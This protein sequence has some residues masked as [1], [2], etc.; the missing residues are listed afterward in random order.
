MQLEQEIDFK[1]EGNKKELHLR[2]KVPEKIYK[3]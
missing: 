2:A 1:V 3:E